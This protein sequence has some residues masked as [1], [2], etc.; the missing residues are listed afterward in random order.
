MNERWFYCD[1]RIGAELVFSFRSKD[2]IIIEATIPEVNWM[3]SKKLTEVR[4]WFIDNK[5]KVVELKPSK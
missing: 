1:A 5:A 2:D 3:I 4:Q